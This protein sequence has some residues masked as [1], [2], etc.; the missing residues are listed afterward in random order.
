MRADRLEP[1]FSRHSHNPS[2]FEVAAATRFNGQLLDFCVPVN[3]YFPPAD[4]SRRIHESLPELLKYYPDYADVHQAAIASMIGVPTENVVVANGS[5]EL[6]TSLCRDIDG[7]ILTPIPTFGRWIDV[8]QE[9]GIPISFLPRRAKE[10]FHIGIDE[11]QVAIPK[12]GAS[13]VVLCNPDNPTGAALSLETIRELMERLTPL[14]LFVIDE[15]FIDFSG[16][17][18]AASLAIE[19]SNTIV[20]KSLGKSLG[21]HGIRAGYAVANTRLAAQLRRKLPY[22]NVNGIASFVLKSLPDYRAEYTASFARVAADRESMLARLSAIAGVEVYPSH[23]NFLYARLRQVGSG[24][25]LRTRLLEEHGVLIRECGNKLGANS[26]H[27]RLAVLPPPAVERLAYALE[28][29]ID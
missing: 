21:W 4:L 22:W 20:I 26:D 19:S 8:P 17:E 9:L 5:T 6:I 16:I 3:P 24:P 13:T 1:L 14:S 23:A 11:L 27:L 25:A 10:A 7:P 15:S 2:F 28:E 18:S 12:T 29:C